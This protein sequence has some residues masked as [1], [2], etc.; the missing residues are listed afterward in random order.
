MSD[1]SY[2]RNSLIAGASIVALGAL[3]APA[4]AQTAPAPAAGDAA[5]PAAAEPVAAPDA[6]GNDVIVTA[7]HRQTKLQK[8]PVAVSVFTGAS[9]DRIGINSVQDVT[10]FAPGFV[11]SP[12]T[13]H[14]YLRGVGRQSIELTDDSRVATYEDGF[15]VVSPYQLDKSSLFLSQEQI[16]RG[17]QNVGGR[18]AAA[19]SIDM[20]SARP[21]DAP[22]AEVRATA[23]NFDHYEVEAAAS[24]QVLPGLD[25]RLAGYD[26]QQSQG[27]YKNLTG[28]PSE[29]G[30]INEWYLEGQ[31]DLKLG[32]NA[33][34]WV[35]GYLSNWHNRGDA[36][37]RD[38]GGSEYGNGSWDETN[39]TDSNTYPG[40]GLFINPNIG[41]AGFAGATRIAAQGANPAS[42]IPVLGSTTLQAPGIFNNPGINNINNF[43]AI[44][45][46]TVNL[47]D[48]D[49]INT[50]FTYHF[51]TFDFKYVGGYQQ[52]N[53]NLNYSEPDTDVTGFNLPGSTV[54]PAGELAAL[55]LPG[56]SQLHINPL[57]NLNYQQDDQWWSNEVSLQS[58]SS[59][60]LQWTA[61]LYYYQEHYTNPIEISAPGQAN[62]AHP[63]AALPTAFGGVGPLAGTFAAPNPQN[64]IDFLNYNLT[65]QSA[66][67]YGQ[68]S[69]KVN[70]DFKIVGDLRYT[71]DH[72]FGTE[73]N[74]EVAFNNTLI[75][76]LSPF[77]GADTPSLDFTLA[78]TCPTG[79]ST[80]C[81][82]GHLA[83]GVTSIG[84]VNPNTGIESRGL[85]DSSSAVTGGAGIEWTP[86]NDIFVYARYNRGYEDLTFNAGFIAAAPEVAPETINSYEVGYKQNFG[87]TLSIDVA[88]FYYDY[89]NLQLPTAVLNQ[90]SGLV[91]TQFINV[92]KSES[93]GVEFEGTWNPIRNLVITASYSFDYTAIL[94]G[95]SGTVTGGVLTPASGA[96]CDGDT[97]DPAAVAKGA[98]PFPGQ[99]LAASGVLQQSIQGSPLPE[100]P[101]NKIAFSVA[102]TWHFDPGGLTLAGSYSWRDVQ[103]G[104][105]FNRF[106]DNAPSWDDVDLR[107]LWTANHDRYEIIGYVKNLF[108]DN[109]FEAADGGTGLLGNATSSTT[110]AKGLNE[111]NIFTLAPP[112]TFGVEVRYKFF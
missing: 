47:T 69:Y 112:R 14:A 20:I 83:K 73:F 17:P 77:F 93:T 33:D 46:R 87:H 74:R 101:R 1:S 44:E 49:D 86:T 82:A 79:I 111:E 98:K 32:D 25:L 91:Q 64:T 51:P 48:Y 50:V 88:G 39:F 42:L 52:Y 62:F 45:D 96:L 16:E 12:T 4:L 36:G 27:Y 65:V 100:A 10:N 3:T 21:T 22:Y 43:A 6:G 53:Y 66:A 81:G 28:G 19:G 70:D 30:A 59:S 9:R 92:P 5:S 41:Y 61:G 76:G 40:A 71:D 7:E 29:G 35:R 26:N 107:L 89:D 78:G 94:T 95:C 110:A 85:G 18:N 104:T 72:K 24:G 97:N 34:L 68:V 67:A 84:V 80:S 56:Q 31:G 75:G 54:T 90:A 23:G 11:Y 103:D 13:T 2:L 15:Y 105:V 60:P 99:S 102:Y 106:Y 109:Q 58:T 55:G 37:S 8:V 108:N 57:V 63:L 38:G